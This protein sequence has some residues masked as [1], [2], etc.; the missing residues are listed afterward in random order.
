MALAASLLLLAAHP[1]VAA[2]SSPATRRCGVTKPGADCLGSDLPRAD[3]GEVGSAAL[4]C[5]VPLQMLTRQ[6]ISRLPPPPGSAA[7]Q[8]RGH[9][10]LCPRHI[11]HA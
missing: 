8:P 5:Q 9:A 7:A 6:L 2:A 11:I 10:R 3:I 4:C 1:G